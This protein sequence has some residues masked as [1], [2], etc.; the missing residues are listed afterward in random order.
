MKMYSV[1]LREIGREKMIA[2]ILF[3]VLSIKTRLIV[4]FLK[5]IWKNNLYATH[6]HTRAK[7]NTISFRKLKY[8]K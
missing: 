7:R 5:F 8:K 1:P 3:F 4:F 2:Q 6:V